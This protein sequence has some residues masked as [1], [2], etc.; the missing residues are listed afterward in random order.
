MS[1]L[2]DYR[3]QRAI[4]W[5]KVLEISY[6]LIIQLRGLIVVWKKKNS[7]GSHERSRRCS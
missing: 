3:L 7:W 4:K 1:N 6:K 2:S 5:V